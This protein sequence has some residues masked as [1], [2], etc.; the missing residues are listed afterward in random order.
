MPTFD[1][2]ATVAKTSVSAGNPSIQKIRTATA[3]TL[4]QFMSS[5][6]MNLVSQSKS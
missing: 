5:V 1:L 3:A 6:W 4:Y 2:T